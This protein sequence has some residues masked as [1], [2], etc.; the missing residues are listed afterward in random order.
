MKS[1]RYQRGKE[2]YLSFDPDQAK[3]MLEYLKSVSPE[4]AQYT[5]EFMYGDIMSRPVLDIKLR[6]L[7][8][9]GILAAKETATAQLKGH[10]LAAFKLGCSKEEIREAIIQ[11][12]IYS[13]F[14]AA[15]N[16]MK[17]AN[18]VFEKLEED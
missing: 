18:K 6:T 13:G 3:E 16:A 1:E 8:G 14:P 12:V 15:V 9:I 11:T 10:I 7:I 2:K 4:L 17:A 5:I